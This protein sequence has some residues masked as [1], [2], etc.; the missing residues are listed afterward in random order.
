MKLWT[1]SSLKLIARG[2]K[3]R[4]MFSLPH[5]DHDLGFLI[6]YWKVNTS[7]RKLNLKLHCTLCLT[8]REPHAKPVFFFNIFSGGLHFDAKIIGVFLICLVMGPLEKKHFKRYFL[9]C[10][11]RGGE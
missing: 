7:N 6:N 4:I 1:N 10:Q 8:G 5:A 9:R 3:G 2:F 11:G